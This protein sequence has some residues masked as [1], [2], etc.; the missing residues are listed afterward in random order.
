[1]VA[2]TRC[3]APPYRLT[4]GAYRMLTP[5]MQDKCFDLSIAFGDH[6]LEF[7]RPSRAARVRRPT[8]RPFLRLPSR[9]ARF[10]E[11]TSRFGNPRLGLRLRSVARNM[12]EVGRQRRHRRGE[13]V[14]HGRKLEALIPGHPRAQVVLYRGVR[15]ASQDVADRLGRRLP[16]IGIDPVRSIVNLRASNVGCHMVAPSGCNL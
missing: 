11:V 8:R 4:R 13:P 7:G 10:S 15:S 12:P 9:R 6:L 16:A 3:Q 14:G 1:M 2:P 5:D